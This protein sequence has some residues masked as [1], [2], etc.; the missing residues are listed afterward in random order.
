MCDGPVGFVAPW[1]SLIRGSELLSMQS[2][3]GDCCSKSNDLSCSWY[4]VWPLPNF[5]RNLNNIYNR[6]SKATGDAYSSWHLPTFHFGSVFPQFVMFSDFKFRISLGN[7]YFTFVQSSVFTW[8]SVVDFNVV[9]F[10]HRCTTSHWKAGK[11]L[12]VKCW[13]H[14]ILALSISNK[15]FNSIMII[16]VK[17]E[18]T[19]ALS[20]WHHCR[21]YYQIISL[22][23]QFLLQVTDVFLRG[24]K[25]LI[26]N[27]STLSLR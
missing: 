9:K 14:L 11:H 26:Y 1:P 15:L 17:Y 18:R 19:D 12:I 3:K 4:R 8:K 7:F 24:T 27:T 10:V 13:R 25:V 2:L 21:S 20:L 5:L 6:F 23:K 16:L 22:N